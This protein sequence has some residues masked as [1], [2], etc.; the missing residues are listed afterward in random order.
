MGAVA[1]R[2][3][4]RAVTRGAK[5][6][7]PGYKD[8]KLADRG[9]RKRADAI[10]YNDFVAGLDD[11]GLEAE[12]A[13]VLKDKPSYELTGSERDKYM[14]LELASEARDAKKGIYY[15]EA[16]E[17]Y[18]DAWDYTSKDTGKKYSDGMSREEFLEMDD[19][20]FADQW[21]RAGYPSIT[22]EAVDSIQSGKAT[23]DDVLKDKK[24]L[25]DR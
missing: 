19:E 23:L 5:D 25:V 18:E 12:Y 1:S 13:K 9:Q 8:A 7:L 16:P 22:D 3:V 10:V 11:A 21:A 17:M 20:I 14:A 4:G 6:I 15:D 2:G 24:N